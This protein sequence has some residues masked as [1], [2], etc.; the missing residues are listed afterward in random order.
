MTYGNPQQYTLTILT[1]T[2]KIGHYSSSML[3]IHTNVSYIIIL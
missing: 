3:S 1:N 2:I